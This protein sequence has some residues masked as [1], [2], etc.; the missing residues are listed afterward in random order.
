M[1]EHFLG[2]YPLLPLCPLTARYGS[3]EGE[4]LAPPK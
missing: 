3:F 1:S 2:K 4:G